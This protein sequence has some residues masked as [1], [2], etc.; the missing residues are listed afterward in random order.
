MIRKVEGR[1]EPKESKCL[2]ASFFRPLAK[3]GRLLDRSGPRLWGRRSL[4]KDGEAVGLG[5]G[6]HKRELA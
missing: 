3:T 6:C 2:N 5:K 4:I 1:G